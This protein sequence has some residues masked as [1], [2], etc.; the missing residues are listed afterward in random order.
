[1]KKTWLAVPILTLF[2]CG[3]NNN[4]HPSI[5]YLGMTPPGATAQEFAPGIVSTDSFEHSSPVFSPD[6]TLVFWNIISRV[7]PAQLLEMTYEDGKWSSPHN[8][9]FGDPTADDFYPSFSSDGKTLYFS[10]RRKVPAGYQQRDMR[11]WT[12]VRNG[13]SWG[14]PVPFDSTVSTGMEYAHS[15]TNDNTLYFSA[16]TQ[17]QT[18]FDIF[19]SRT[20]M[21]F[22]INS[23][24]YEDGAFIAPDESFLIFESQR[25]EGIDGSIDLYIS[26]KL[27]D[28][29]WSLPV[30][31][32][33]TINS[34]DTER[35]AKISPDGKFLFFGSNRN[36]TPPAWGFDIYWIETGVIDELKNNRLAKTAID[37]PL[38]EELLKALA[39]GNASQSIDLLKSW[40]SKYPQDMEGARVYV[41][42]LRKQKM[43]A[44]AEALIASLPADWL[45]SVM[46]R[47]D[48]ALTKFG[49]GKVN[50]AEKILE[51]LLIPSP[52]LEV[53]LRQIVSGLDGIGLYD[54]ADNYFDRL[55]T[56]GVNPVHIYNR[57][58][59]YAKAGEKDRAF[60]FLNVAADKGYK[61]ASQYENDTDLISLKADRRWKSLRKK[62]N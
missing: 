22:G 5:D 55:V 59:G 28:G 36:Q 44:E 12:V 19:S 41:A 43:Y 31:M 51:P 9:S 2:A 27:D 50:E 37:Q 40:T 23:V 60:A 11:I 6:G 1:M 46:L 57:A 20:P 13:N 48:I 38:G 4:S 54:Q 14:T 42:E 34:G 52:D 49:A 26:F 45:N 61:A 30:N 24:G 53:T 7:R 58:C 17:G 8:P 18:N 3:A 10:S 32:G 15:I 25:A 62:L 33:P 29:G 47:T 16:R 56:N 35:M 39:E 21:P